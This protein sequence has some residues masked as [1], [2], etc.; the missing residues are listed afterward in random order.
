MR[1]EVPNEL[2]DVDVRRRVFFN[3]ATI[4]EYREAIDY[5]FHLISA[6]CAS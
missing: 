3:A 4:I 1:P 5:A 6:T 2:V